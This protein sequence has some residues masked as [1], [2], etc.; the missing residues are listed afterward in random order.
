MSD[1]DQHNTLL[2]KKIDFTDDQIIEQ[3]EVA[4]ITKL[5]F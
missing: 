1:I 4:G 3:K 5:I 2:A